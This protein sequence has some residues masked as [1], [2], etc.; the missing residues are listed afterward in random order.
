MKMPMKKP[1]AK[2]AAVPASLKGLPAAFVK[3]ALKKKAA[4]KK[5]K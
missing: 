5:G 1:A 4:A 3:N 2:K